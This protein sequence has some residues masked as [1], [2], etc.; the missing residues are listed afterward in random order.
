MK[1]IAN[2]MVQRRIVVIFTFVFLF[3]IILLVRLGYVQFVLSPFLVGQAEELW[4]R[5]IVFEPERGKIV[6]RNGEVLAEN[7]SAPTVMIVPRQIEDPENTAK[8]LA[9]TLSMDYDRALEEITKN[10]RIVRLHPEGRKISEEK[11]RAIQEL[12][13]SGVYVAEDSIRHYPKGDY[14]SHVLGFSG[15]D[16]QGLTGLELFY[17]EQLSG[18]PGSLSFYSDAKGRRM[19]HKAD[20]YKEPV[21]GY[22]LKLTVDNKIQTIIE[23]EL[24]IAENKYNPDGAIAIA[25]NPKNGSI[26]GMA[27]RP[28]FDPANYQEISAEVYNR[29]LP[30]WSTYEPGSTFKIITLAAA[31]EEGKVDLLEDDFHDHGSV[32]VGGTHLHC[33]KSGGHGHQTFLEVVQN[34]CNPGFVELGQRL[35]KEQLFSYIEK[36][37]F[38]TKTGIDLQGEANGILFNLENVGP[39]ELGTTSFGQ[40]VSVTPIQQ[41]MAVSAAINGGYLYEPYVAEGFIDPTTGE[42]VAEKEPEMK[43]R[44]ISQNTSEQIRD[45]L[46]H[47]VALGTGRS[48]FVEGYR[49]GGKTGTAQKVGP[50]GGYMENNHIVSFIGFAPANDPEIVVY[51]A[52][53]NPKGVV[54]FG[55]VVAAPIVGTIISDSLRALD[56]PKQEDGIEKDYQW[57]EEPLVEI[58][59]LIGL[60]TKEL[61][62]YY[63]NFQIDTVGDGNVIL[64]QAPAAG[65]KVEQGSK[66]RVVLGEK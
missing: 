55:G 23:R 29:N 14:L 48:A 39:I 19:P 28:N 24:D 25:V 41:V 6:D 40:G 22:D 64:D 10:E 66:I 17:E 54:Q 63:F 61:Q 7:V 42:L 21:D 15:I 8:Q 3:F 65:E 38:G 4:S 47:V 13:L 5:D 45:A 26:L 53:D 51:V 44:V 62:S 50:D 11:A 57:P 35:G 16:N 27:S 31:L 18:T 52:V 36:F 58:P 20:K 49:L 43:R 2:I 9:E 1:R 60:E 34:S 46:E 59:D 32:E 56:V 30:I 33:W 12:A 37:G